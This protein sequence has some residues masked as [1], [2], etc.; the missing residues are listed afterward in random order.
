MIAQHITIFA[1]KTLFRE[2][3]CG[4]VNYCSDLSNKDEL[5]DT[6][7]EYCDLPDLVSICDPWTGTTTTYR[8]I[9]EE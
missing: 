6:C 4:S 7:V 2:T 1:P 9:C 3:F 5:P 8:K